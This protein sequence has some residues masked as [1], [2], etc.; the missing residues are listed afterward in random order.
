MIRL[1]SAIPRSLTPWVKSFW[2]LEVSG[3]GDAQLPEAG[4]EEQGGLAGAPGVYQEE[5]IPDGHHELIFHITGKPARVRTGDG[6]WQQEPMALL[7]AQ[8]LQQHQLELEPGARLYGIRFYPHTLAAFLP[9]PASELTNRVVELDA[10]TDAGPFW[11]CIEE[12]PERTFA[13]FERVLTEKVMT[14]VADKP[15]YAYVEAAVNSILQNRGLF[16]G[17]RLLQRTGISKVY[18]D[19]LFGKYVGIPPKTFSRIIQLN[20]FLACKAAMPSRTLT[21]CSYEAG[22][23]DQ[24]HLT[25]AFHQFAGHSPK[26]YFRRQSAISEI[27]S[28]L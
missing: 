12:E 1:Q 17:A 10:L 3:S 27:F 23:Y 4:W 18:L 24:S 20:H 8:T 26:E 5:I 14:G 28:A 21:D 6:D 13:N 25:R 16:P 2:Y 9:I 22:Y 15:G 11:N 7:S 19:K